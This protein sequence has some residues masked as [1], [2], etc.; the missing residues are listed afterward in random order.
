M[1]LRIVTQNMKKF[2]DSKRLPEG[3]K[4]SIRD[5]STMIKKM[6]QY[7]KELRT[8][9]THLKLAEDCLKKYNNN[10]DRVCKVEQVSVSPRY[11]ESWTSK[12]MYLK[13]C[14]HLKLSVIFFNQDKFFRSNECYS[15]IIK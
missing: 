12:C 3:E 13:S 7:Q 1:F 5:L 6:P 15:L 11:V 9:S 4:Q 8:Y 14:L 2:T 10:V